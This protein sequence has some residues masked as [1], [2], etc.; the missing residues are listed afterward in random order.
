MK[1]EKI[2]VAAAALTTICATAHGYDLQSKALTPITLQPA[3]AGAPMEFARAGVPAFSIEGDVSNPDVKWGV[4]LISNCVERTVGRPP[5]ARDGKFRIR[6][7]PDADQ[8]CQYVA[9]ETTADGVTLGGN[10]RFAALDFAERVLGVRWYFPGEFGTIYPKTENLTIAPFA[11]RDEAWFKGRRGDKFYVYTSVDNKERV[12]HWRP[13]MGELNV[14]MVREFVD[15]WKDGGRGV[16]GGSHS[17]I[18]EAIAKNHPDKL[19]TIFYTSPYGK[20]WHNPLYHIGNAYNVVD[21]KFADLLIDDWKLYYSSNGKVDNGDYRRDFSSDTCSFGVCDT[22]LPKSEFIGNPTVESLGLINPADDARGPEAWACN[23]YG[24]FY[25]YL[26]NRL[27]REMPDKKLFLLIYY[28]ALHAP[29]DRRFALPDNVEVNVCVG[30]LPSKTR[31]PELAANAV[32]IFREWYEALGGR[33]ALKAWLYTEVNDRFARA[34]V[35]EFVGDVP[36]LLGKYL[37]REG[38]VFY[39]FN[40]GKDMWHYFWSVYG[41]WRAQWNPD[42]DPDAAVPEIMRDCVGEK[43]GAEMAEFHRI[44]K[45]TY[46][47]VVVATK[48]RSAAMPVET[49][50]RLEARIA[51]ARAAVTPGTVEARRLALMTDFWDEALKVYRTLAA[52]EPPIY[53]VK[54]WQKGM[55]WKKVKPMPLFVTTTG[56]S[57]VTPAAIRLAWDE[58]GLYGTVEA[59]YA[60]RADRKKDLWSNDSIEMLFTPGLGKEQEYQFAFD[61]LGREYLMKQRHLPINQPADANFKAPGFRHSAKVADSRWSGEFF[62]PWSAFEEGAPKVYD[63]WNANFVSN[64]LGGRRE[65]SG[66]SFTMGK[67]HNREMFGILRFMGLGD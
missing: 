40:G 39:D 32:R 15:F 44:L 6:F 61:C 60:P 54:R 35:P 51:A 34:M 33:P 36:K 59:D 2:L 11:Y 23:I 43:A 65:V 16:K 47:D 4:A 31:N 53:E 49:I 18:P 27:K 46:I 24:R 22:Y 25:Q 41:V 55:D 21:L 1:T 7:R 37:S 42:Y 5:L 38:G 26:G 8:K 9:M 28:Q 13:Y 52:Y 30:D 66:S 57:A 45:K 12:D 48:S 50:G 10:P 63:Q 56:A 62:I 29:S 14:R 67:N 19:K 17:P 58:A 3:P 64:R 20:F